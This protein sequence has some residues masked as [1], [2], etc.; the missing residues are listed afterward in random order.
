MTEYIPA[1]MNDGCY[2]TFVFPNHG[3]NSSLFTA[4]T[5]RLTNFSA[6]I[7]ES[8]AICSKI[9]CRSISAGSV[10]MTSAIFSPFSRPLPEV[11]HALHQWHE[12]HVLPFP[13]HKD[14]TEYLQLYSHP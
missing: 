3:N 12:Y 9:S 1:P 14:D 13:A 8:L 6:Y 10:Q 5:T 2:V 11:Q 4:T 7:K